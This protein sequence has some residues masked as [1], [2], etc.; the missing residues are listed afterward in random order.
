MLLAKV[1][2]TGHTSLSYH[3]FARHSIGLMN[4]CNSMNCSHVNIRRLL[5]HSCLFRRPVVP[6]LQ[7]RLKHY[8]VAT[9]RPLRTSLKAK[10]SGYE[11]MPDAH[12]RQS[13]DKGAFGRYIPKFDQSTGP[14]TVTQVS[15]AQQLLSFIKRLGVAALLVVLG[16]GRALSARAR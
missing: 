8:H 15:I 6:C 11:G 12:S 5:H 14:N 3:V 16:L 4:T 2:L 10:A 1:S 13:S 7:L 9:Q